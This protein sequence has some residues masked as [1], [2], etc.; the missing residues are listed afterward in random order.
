MTPSTETRLVFGRWVFTGQSTLTNGALAIQGDTIAAV[1][2]QEELRR[3]YP[4]AAVLGSHTFAVMPGLINAHHHSNGVPNSLQGVSDDFLEPWLFSLLCLRSQD[5]YLRTLFSIAQLL[6]SG[7]TT[8]LDVASISGAVESCHD[9]LS[10]RLKA[11]DQ[12]GMRVALAPGANYKSFLVHG[13]DQD[14]AFLESLPVV[15]AQTVRQMVPLQE[16]LLPEDY[17][18]LIGD[19]AKAHHSH[20]HMKVWF[21]PPG[22]QWVEDD[23]MVKIATAAE[24]LGT[25]I[26]THVTESFYEKLLG[27]KFYGKSVIAHLDDLGVLSPR[28]SMAHGVWVTEDDIQILAKTGASISHNPSSNLRLRAGVLPL[29]ALLAVDTTVGLGIDGT[30]IGDDEDMFA[31]MR[32]AARLHREPQL[33]GSAP[34]W[35]E[36]FHLATQ[37][38]AKLLMQEDSLGRLA[39]G[40]KADVVLVDCD[41]ITWPWL[42]PD[43]NPLEVML[44]RAK[45]TDVD[46]VLVNGNIVL[47]D[48][49]PT[50]F[51]LNA[52]GA[53]LAEELAASANRQAYR[54]LFAEVR[55]Y[56]ES[57]YAAW[58]VPGLEPY[59]M[60]NSR[61]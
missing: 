11:Y 46:T 36:I 48:G 50:G 5:P 55:P 24:A 53:A 4:N 1:G 13:D 34:A 52:V 2:S 22:P 25:G 26:Q 60:F 40:F 41:R 39:P 47:Q 21:G 61:V 56:I 18:G 42:S 16:P 49:Q 57:W 43:A 3:K 20:P 19:L 58:Q 17:L 33:K 6:R 14:E 30:A 37:G 9:N 31:E 27:P 35:A 10:S 12:A 29:N 54:D 15:L 45:A 28:F 59:A 23:L 32:L 38:S 51:D 8:V 7:V 44:M